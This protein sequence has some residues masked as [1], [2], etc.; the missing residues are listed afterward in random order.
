MALSWDL[1]EIADHE[2]LW[3]EQEEKGEDGEPRYKLDAITEG[4]IWATIGIGIGHWTADEAPEIYARLKLV[5]KIDGPLFYKMV[6]GKRED[7][8]VTPEMVLRHVGLRTNVS[9]EARGRWRNRLI[10]RHFKDAM[11]AEA[12]KAEEVE[13]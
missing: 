9:H 6:D 5:E 12:F 4:F 7:T 2:D 11:A 3:H 10:D 8:L 13:A 1:S